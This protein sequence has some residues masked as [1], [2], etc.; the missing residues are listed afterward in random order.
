MSSPF[1]PPLANRPRVVAILVGSFIGFLAGQILAELLETLAASLGHY[2]GG[3]HALLLSPNPPWWA[4]TVGLLGLWVGFY[5]AVR[6][7]YREGRLAPWPD[8][9][10]GRFGDLR[11]VVLGV[12]CQFIV[13]LAY[14]PFNLKNFDRPAQHLFGGATGAGFILVG[15]LTVCGAPVF[16]EWLFRGVLFRALS[17]GVTGMSQRAA[18]TFGVVVSALLFGIA[19]GEP[20]QF[21]GLAGL[22]IVLAIVAWRSKRLVPSFLT[23]AS[24]NATAFVAVIVQ[25]SGH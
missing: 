2:H 3:E 22:G 6:Y 15:I 7:A 17:E 20:E 9:W 1:A 23:H 19:H 12:A 25:R 21:A 14:A 18:V 24:F 5:G 8:Q 11:Y 10:R 4:T 13:D 16:E